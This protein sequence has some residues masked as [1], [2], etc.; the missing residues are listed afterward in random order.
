M[1]R[2]KDVIRRRG[3]N[4]SSFEVETEVITHPAVK[5]AAAVAVPSELS[6]DEVLIAVSLA[7]GETLRP[8][9]TRHLSHSA[10]ATLHG[11]ALRADHGRFAQDADPENP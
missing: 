5:E 11:A 8:R 9:G 10:H 3:E 1:D 6:E 2:L 7:D 4:I